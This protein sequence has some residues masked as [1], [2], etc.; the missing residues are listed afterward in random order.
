MRIVVG[1]ASGLIGTALR[2]SL[3][4]DGHEVQ[5]LVRREARAPD[6]IAWDPTRGEIDAEALKAADGV[7]NLAGAGLGD[8]R[9]TDEY[10]QV[11]R[12]SRIDST[13]LIAETLAAIDPR[14]PVLVN[15]SA[16]GIYGPDRGD[17]VL[18]ESSTLGRGFLADLVR[19][20]EAATAP[21]QAAGVRVCTLRTGLVMTRHGGA[22]QRQLPFFR[23]GLGGPLGRGKQWWSHVSLVDTV[24]AMRFLLE[25]ETCS[26]PYD[27][28][29]P[30]PVTNAE[31]TRVL[32]RTLGRPALL[33]VPSPALQIYLGEFAGDVLGSLRILPTRLLEAGFTFEHP[34]A[35]SVVRAA[36]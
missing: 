1:G 12:D 13:R 11:I 16:S 33:P 34:D 35:E 9:W 15:A 29:A 19:D 5:R 17:E 26:G 27:V 18:D 3:T 8:R 14:P 20:W 36:L 28:T 2:D 30:E 23:L 31:F 32:A 4:T 25:C 22:L 6:E 10:K 21:A 7:V 24:R